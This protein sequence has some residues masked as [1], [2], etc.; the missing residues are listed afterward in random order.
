[1]RDRHDIEPEMVRRLEDALGAELVSVVL[2]G[3]AVHEDADAYRGVGTT[4]L[5]IVLSDLELE[6]VGRAGEP[7][8]WWLGRGQPWPRLFTVE[9]LRA[10]TDIYPIEMLDIV[11]HHRV[12]HGTDPVMAATIDRAQLRLQCERE[13][14]EKLMRLREG[15]V[16]C[17]GRAGA[18]RDLL[19]VSYASFAQV[20][21]GCLH[22]LGEPVPRH[23]HDVVRALGDRLDLPRAGFEHAEQLARG[24]AGDATATFTEYYRALSLAAERID[25]FI[26]HEGRRS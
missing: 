13:L 7:I 22:L 14:R 11:R 16:E 1:M 17:S 18:L 8:R 5:M 19:A 12:L 20:F 4:H 21:R 15:Y 3:P 6:T 23:D 25:R 10:S 26:T 24:A 2:Y 9:S